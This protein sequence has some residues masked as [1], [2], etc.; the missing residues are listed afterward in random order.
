MAIFLSFSLFEGTLIFASIWQ[1]I[2]LDIEFWV[3]GVTSNSHFFQ[4]LKM[5]H[6]LLT[7][8]A[9]DKKSSVIQIFFFLPKDDMWFFFHYF[10]NFTLSLLIEVWIGCILMWVSLGLLWFIQ[11]CDYIGLFLLSSVEIFL[12]YFF[13]YI[14]VPSSLSSS[15][16]ILIT[17]MLDFQFSPQV[18]ETLLLS[19][20]I[21]LLFSLLSIVQI[22]S[23]LCSTVKFTDSIIL[24]LYFV[25]E[26]IVAFFISSLYCSVPSVSFIS[27]IC[28]NISFLYF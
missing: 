4:V 20:V 13:E 11:F 15:S 12:P 19:L 26:P 2:S 9:S 25:F 21:I 10:Q 3:L 14:S 7:S 23:F 16:G 17:Q 28:W 1:D 27:S 22:C 18:S 24:P 6:F 8:V 5:C